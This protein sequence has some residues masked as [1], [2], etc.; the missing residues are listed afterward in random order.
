MFRFY[1]ILLKLFIKLNSCE[2]M[3]VSHLEERVDI[4]FCTTI[5]YEKQQNVAKCTHS[6]LI[7]L[8]WKL[9]CK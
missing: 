2:N 9:I 6:S 1:D 3:G 8:S 5:D 7:K 4:C